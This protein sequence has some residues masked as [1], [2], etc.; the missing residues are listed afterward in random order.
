[1][2]ENVIPL[3]KRMA[4]FLLAEKKISVVKYM[5]FTDWVMPLL[6]DNPK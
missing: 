5:D 6:V 2:P 1:M 3:S 4:R